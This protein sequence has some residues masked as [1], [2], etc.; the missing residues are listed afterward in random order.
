M[1]DLWETLVERIKGAL[2]L[3]LERARVYSD[4]SPED[5]ERYNADIQATNI[6]LQGHRNNARGTGAAGKRGAQNRVRN[7]NPGQARQ[8][9]CY[10]CNNVDELSVHDLALNMDNVFQADECDAFDYDVDEAPTTQTVFMENVSSTDPVYDEAGPS[11]DSNILSEY[12]KDNAKPVVQNNVSSVPNDAY[13]KYD[14]IERKNLLIA[15]DN[16]IADCLSREVFYIATNSELTVSRFT[17]MHDAYTFVQARFLELEAELSKL[18]AKIKKDDHNELV[19][20]FSNLETT[21]LLTENENIKVQIN[22]KMKCVTMDSVIPKV[23]APGLNNCTN[24]SGSKPRSNTKKNR[25]SSAK[26]VNKKKVEEH[27]RTNKSSLT[28]AI[29]VDSSIISKR[30]GDYVIG[31]NEIYRVYYVEEIGHNLFSVR[32]FC[33]FDLEVAFRKHSCYVQDTYGVELIKG[34]VAGSTIIKDNPVAT[35][36][37][38]PFIN[39][40]ASEPSSKASSFGDISS[41]KSIHV[42]KLVPQP[43]CVMIIALKWIYKV[44]LDEYGDVL[45]NK[46]QLMAKG[47]QQEEG[48]DFEE[49]FASIAR[50][51][52]IRIF[53]ANATSKNM[54]IYQMDVKIAFLNGKLKEEVY[55]SQPEGFVD[56]D[57]PTHVYRLKKALYGLKLSRRTKK[58]VRSA[59]FLKDKLVSWSSKKQKSTAISTIDAEYITMSGCSA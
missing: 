29:R 2:H 24:A 57:H 5:K 15:N 58:Y 26:S 40:F 56:P 52:A 53:I 6:L 11:Y 17:E 51:E 23:I 27:P 55:V 21:A 50:I 16:L 28:K 32:Q 36:D 14:E 9:K 37:T 7:V 34:V 35:A 18:N 13:M 49:L 19:K 12:V 25:T 59:Q 54:I 30:T 1:K 42:W 44:K 8:I 47:Y 41:Y 38:D 22:E 20:C 3:G 39:V 48:I 31:D 43:D 46:A 4:L 45:K 33:N 10:N